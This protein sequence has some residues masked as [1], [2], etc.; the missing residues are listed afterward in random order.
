MYVCDRFVTMSIADKYKHAH[1]DPQGAGDGRPTAMQIL[2]DEGLHGKL[3][4]T[5]ALIT[6]G[7]GG[8]G[9]ETAKVLHAAGCQVHT[10]TCR[11]RLGSMATVHIMWS[12]RV[13]TA[14][15]RAL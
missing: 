13:Y 9:L 10:P 2:E 6:G 12:R 14:C 15:Q 11:K 8:L 3:G 4:G 1:K 5:V 7:A